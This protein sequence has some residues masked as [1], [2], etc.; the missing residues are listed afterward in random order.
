MSRPN[1]PAK[2][3]VCGREDFIILMQKYE[4]SNSVGK[5]LNKCQ[6]PIDT[7]RDFANAFANQEELTKDLLGPLNVETLPD[8][9]RISARSAVRGLWAECTALCRVV[10]DNKRGDPEKTKKLAKTRIT[11]KLGFGKKPW[12]FWPRSLR[13]TL[14]WTSNPPTNC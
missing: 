5:Y 6:P 12:S 3:N 1:T 11:S 14:V 8:Q 10:L 7:A 2:V 9:V 4:V 13:S